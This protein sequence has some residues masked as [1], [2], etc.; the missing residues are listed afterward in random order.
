M[1]FY[2]R[3]NIYNS[4]KLKWVIRLRR[5]FVSKKKH[6][7][8]KILKYGFYIL[9]VYII[10]KVAFCFILNIRFKVSNEEFL[11][12]LISDSNHHLIYNKNSKELMNSAIKLLSNITI[13]N[14]LTIVTSSFN[15]QNKS[16][17]NIDDTYENYLQ[18]E[19]VTKYVNNPNNSEITNPRV[20]I[21]NSH[22]LENYGYEN[23]E[24][25]GLTPNVMVASYL[26]QDSLNKK[27]IK[28]LV[29]EA[30]IT[31]FMKENNLDS[32]EASRHY[33]LETLKNNP[34]LELIIDLHRDALSHKNSTT[35]I[36]NKKC[37]KVLFVVGLE[38]KNYE[39]NLQLANTLNNLIKK[40]YSNLTRGVITKGGKNVNGI[41]NQDVSS[42]IILLEL[43]G[44]ESTLEEIMNTSDILSEII[45]EYLGEKYE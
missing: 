17:V 35:T 14:P 18:L 32:Y 3:I 22:Q 6:N 15:I 44:D 40:K 30:N 33:L 9:I 11:K 28:T 25:Y 16:V 45:K 27:N 13:N 4:N 10:Y 20:Y 38:N 21:Y 36:K 34:D 29:E 19:G 24:L 1:T 43:G 12:Y 23:I 39:K 7:F 42:K 8:F 41:Y 26:L 2:L 31:D 37:A 5:R